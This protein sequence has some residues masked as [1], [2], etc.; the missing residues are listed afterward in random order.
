MLIELPFSPS[1]LYAHDIQFYIPLFRSYATSRNFGW[2]KKTVYICP[3]VAPTQYQ[4]KVFQ[5]KLLF[6]L[7]LQADSIPPLAAKGELQTSSN[8]IIFSYLLAY[9]RRTNKSVTNYS[10]QI[11]IQFA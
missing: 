1:R 11:V 8:Q 5:N 9:R 6:L 2:G 4:H 7:L 10:T 3:S